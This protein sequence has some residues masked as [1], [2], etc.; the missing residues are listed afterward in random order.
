MKGNET[1]WKGGNQVK[2]DWACH[3]KMLIYPTE[4]EEPLKTLRMSERDHVG[5]R[6][7]DN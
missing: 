2:K 5:G 6:V 3:A 4:E 7:E 1:V